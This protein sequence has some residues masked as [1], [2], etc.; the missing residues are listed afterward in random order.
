MEITNRTGITTTHKQQSR[1]SVQWARTRVQKI[2]DFSLVALL[3]DLC[4]ILTG[5]SL[6]LSVSARVLPA[7]EPISATPYG[8]Q[9]IVAVWCAALFITPIYTQLSGQELKDELKRVVLVGALAT[10]LTLII[11]T[12]LPHPMAAVSVVATTTLGTVGML[13]WRM[14]LYSLF[15]GVNLVHE[16]KRVLVIGANDHTI[17]YVE[18]VARQTNSP[19]FVCGFIDDRA[20]ETVAGYP[21]IGSTRANLAEI[22]HEYEIEEVVVVQPTSSDEAIIRLFETL[23]FLPVQIHIIPGQDELNLFHPLSV[24][25]KAEKLAVTLPQL[26]MS[27]PNRT[28]KRLLDIVLASIGIFM[29]LPMLVM[30]GIAIKLDSPGPLFFKQ[31]RIGEGGNPFHM[32]KF[33]SMVQ[34]AEQLQSSVMKTNADGKLV[35]KSENDPRVTRIGRIIRKTSIDELPQLLNVL[36]GDMSLVGPRPELPLL[37]NTQYESWQ[38]QRFTVPPG[39]TGWWQVSG[40]KEA[41]LLHLSTEEDLYYIQHYSFWLDLKIMFMTVPVI[42]TG[43]GSF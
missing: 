42:L 41:K 11:S 22:V 18:T 29:V 23:Q 15:P 3:L 35:H 7:V 9:I 17:D 19:L 1:D 36:K 30:V 34:N 13:F 27:L 40:R 16:R 5:V 26:G 43:K 32:Y 25:R 31:K 37:V 38:K 20:E 39:I 21:I 10:G 24:H 2:V 33:R 12:F 4:A 14:V 28:L 8:V 6:A